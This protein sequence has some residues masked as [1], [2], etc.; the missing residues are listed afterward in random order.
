MIEKKSLLNEQNK[1]SVSKFDIDMKV[2]IDSSQNPLGGNVEL[3]IQR[4]IIARINSCSNFIAT[5]GRIGAGQ[6]IITNKLTNEYLTQVFMNV[7][8][9]L[10]IVDDRLENGTVIMG[11]KNDIS[12]PGISLII[13]ENSLNNIVYNK[14]DI[15]EQIFNLKYGFSIAGFYPEKQFYTLYIKNKF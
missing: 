11:R 1:E 6:F 2:L 9:F 3:A 8:H 5:S 10:F 4:K 13:N 14:E 7:G 12:Q 15:D